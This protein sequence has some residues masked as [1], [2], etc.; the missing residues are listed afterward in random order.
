MPVALE[1]G[2]RMGENAAALF[3]SYARAADPSAPL[4]ALPR[5][6]QRLSTVLQMGNAEQVLGA[7]R[8][9]ATTAAA[10][11]AAPEAR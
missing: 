2:G 9:A 10:V 1:M 11:A 6:Q 5:L 4:A 7:Q 3:R 8:R